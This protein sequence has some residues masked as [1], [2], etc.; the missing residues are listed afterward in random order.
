MAI[1]TFN[2]KGLV[3]DNKLITKASEP[4][5]E[6]WYAREFH[7]YSEFSD[8]MAHVY[9][10]ESFKNKS[11][12]MTAKFGPVH[13]NPG[14]FWFETSRIRAGNDTFPS[15]NNL[16]KIFNNSVMY[17]RT[18]NQ[19]L[20]D[21]VITA[22]HNFIDKISASISSYGVRSMND[23][24]ISDNYAAKIDNSYYSEYSDQYTNV[25]ETNGAIFIYSKNYASGFDDFRDNMASNK[26]RWYEDYDHKSFS[27]A[28]AHIQDTYLICDPVEVIW[29]LHF[30]ARNIRYKPWSANSADVIN[31]LSSTNYEF[32][33]TDMDIVPTGNNTALM[34]AFNNVTYPSATDPRDVI[35]YPD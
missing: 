15:Y 4:P 3:F 5:T 16:S 18:I 23:F 2:N 14:R 24:E 20:N 9:G 27:E 19:P 29:N 25:Y 32:T 12:T 22:K 13:V 35:F 11:F 30:D 1:Y 31:T 7:S 26:S 8:Y 33:A 6:G 17:V 28:S 10:D 21:N 34:L